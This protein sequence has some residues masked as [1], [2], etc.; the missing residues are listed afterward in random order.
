MFLIFAQPVLSRKPESLL[1]LYSLASSPRQPTPSPFL[2]SL[3]VPPRPSITPS[4]NPTNLPASPQPKGISKAQIL[5]DYRS[6]T[7]EHCIHIPALGH[8]DST[9]HVGRSHL[10]E[11][12]LLR[13]TLY[14]LQGISGKYVHL[15]LSDNEDQ[16]KLIFVDDSV[17]DQY[18]NNTICLHA[19][20]YISFS[21]VYHFTLD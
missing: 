14:L 16:P 9:V 15:S 12:L 1:F 20:L 7:G 4:L 11:H 18:H 8:T 21:E 5:R 2:A 6:R 10:P 19:L 17:S 3:H 13:D